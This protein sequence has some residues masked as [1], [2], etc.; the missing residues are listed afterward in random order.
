MNSPYDKS[1]ARYER[2]YE[3]HRA[4][5]LSE[6]A[7]LRELVPGGRGL[8]VGAGT[9]RF[10]S[11]LGIMVALDA[12]RPMLRHCREEGVERVQGRAEGLPFRNG[13]F[14][15]VLMVT[16]LCFFD[17]PVT[18]LQEAR[19]VV[20]GDGH[21]TLGILDRDSPP[22]REY[23]NGSGKFLSQARP[24]TTS[25]VLEMLR[26]T[27]WEPSRVIQTL[28]S[29]T[30]ISEPEAFLEGHGQG[31]FVAISARRSHLAVSRR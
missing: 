10:A 24:L 18:A 25:H 29:G 2:W 9:G 13:C 11:P 3:E 7:A 31:L 16:A 19:R 21:L 4:A 20:V 14:D 28:C 12:S 26:A 1:V 15:H 22:G 5:Y 8:E 23:W 27:G 17:D 30:G 6:L